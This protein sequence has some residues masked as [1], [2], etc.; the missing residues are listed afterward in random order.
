MA[1][2]YDG[3]KTLSLKIFRAEGG[4]VDCCAESD[5]SSRS[6][7]FSDEHEDEDEE[8]SVLV[9]DEDDVRDLLL[10]GLVDVLLE[11]APSVMRRCSLL[12]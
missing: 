7:G 2:E 5:N 12:A 8:N 6:S 11:V 1:F 10:G 4:R 9:K 3:D